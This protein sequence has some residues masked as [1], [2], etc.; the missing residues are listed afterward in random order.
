MTIVRRQP[1]N[2]AAYLIECLRFVK[3]LAVGLFLTWVASVA[4]TTTSARADD[5]A[6]AQDAPC[7]TEASAQAMA[8]SGYVTNKSAALGS[9]LLELSLG[10]ILRRAAPINANEPARAVEPQKDTNKGVSQDLAA[11]MSERAI[12]QN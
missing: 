9:G 8:S 11:A 1:F 5:Q 7:Q 12:I 3:T 4:L 2:Y 6:A 10:T